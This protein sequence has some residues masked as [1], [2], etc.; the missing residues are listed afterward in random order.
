MINNVKALM[1][2]GRKKPKEDLSDPADDPL[3]GRSQQTSQPKQS[4]H[5]SVYLRSPNHGRLG[6]RQMS[7]LHIH[8]DPLLYVLFHLN[9][10]SQGWS[11]R[12]SLQL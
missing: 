3:W 4:R 5:F 10:T 12:T 9:G 1:S 11:P 7:S 2:T 6:I 8:S